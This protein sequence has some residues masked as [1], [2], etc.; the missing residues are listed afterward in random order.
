M[1]KVILPFLIIT[2]GFS[3]EITENMNFSKNVKSSILQTTLQIHIQNRNIS[4]LTNKIGVILNKVNSYKFCKNKSYSILPTY[5]NQKFINYYTDLKFKCE[6]NKN[7]LPIFSQ[8][9]AKI[10]NENII[11]IY[12]F[13]YT[14]PKKL[15]NKTQTNL[16]IEAFNYG[17]KKAQKLSNT[18]NKK[19]FMKSI[20]FNTPL[21]N[22]SY[23]VLMAP[24]INLPT[25]K[26]EGQ[27][28]NINANYRFICF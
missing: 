20:N 18:F 6:F 19:C 9:L 2:L 8:L 21:Y 7:K 13:E 3:N 5:K 28:V 25:P 15:Y 11:S 23:K 27:N 26:N 1:K 24:S 16:K 4:K 14:L 17:L 10:Q 12:N 22:R